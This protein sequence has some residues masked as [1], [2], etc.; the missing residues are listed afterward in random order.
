M[1]L[2]R[3]ALEQPFGTAENANG[4]L[5]LEGPR[6]P[7]GLWR[8]KTGRTTVDGRAVNWL[9]GDLTIGGRGYAFASAVWRDDQSAIGPAE[10]AQ[11]AVNTFADRGL[12]RDR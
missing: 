5:Q 10:A 8:P 4:I 2:I 7:G 9:V 1:R 11:L 3:D 6:P 12:L